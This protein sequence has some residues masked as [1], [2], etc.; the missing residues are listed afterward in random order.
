MYDTIQIVQ[1]RQDWLRDY[2]IEVEEATPLPFV[3]KFKVDIPASTIVADIRSILNL[4][5][6]W[7][8]ECSTKD[9]TRKFLVEKIEEAGI[10]VTLNGVVENNTHRPI[11]SDE[12][13]G[14]VMV[15]DY[16]PFIFVNIADA[17]A[18]Q[19]F[20][21]VHELVHIWIGKSAGFDLSNLLPANDPVERLCD[22]VAAEILVPEKRF[23][24]QFG[25]ERNFSRLANY[26]KVSRLVI[27]RRTLDLGLM[28]MQDYLQYYK[29]QQEEW[30]RNKEANDTG[31]GN[32]YNT[33]TGR[34]SKRFAEYI[35]KA[36][37]NGQLLYR[38]A[39]RLTGLTA[40]T[41]PNLIDKLS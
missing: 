5:E 15:D 36:V 2:L 40:K 39:Y 11:P 14:F 21:L 12:C 35:D 22:A 6:N 13:R 31:G 8:I 1:R 10:V 37:K 4:V 16:A 9:A 17:I 3:G 38:D 25:L 26:F 28:S 20:T 7:S 19:I 32:F 27:A 34:V 30:E 18:A 23:K 33:A 24:K 41:F 29:H